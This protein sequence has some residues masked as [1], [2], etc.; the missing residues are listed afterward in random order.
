VLHEL[1]DIAKSVEVTVTVSCD[2]IGALHEF[3]RWPIKWD[4]FYDNLMTYKSMPVRLNL[5]TTVSILN[6][7]DLPNIQAFAREHGIDHS[8]AYLKEPA[9][10]DIDNKDLAAVDLYIQKQKELRGIRD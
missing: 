9:V 1:N 8:Y 2:G 4:T 6:V 3:M 7:D 10:L 5:W